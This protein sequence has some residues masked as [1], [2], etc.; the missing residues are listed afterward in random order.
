MNRRLGFMGIIVKDKGSV[1]NKINEIISEFGDFVIARLGIPYRE[2]ECSV[3]TLIVDIDT[4]TLGKFAGKL[5]SL[6]G[7]SVKSA[8][9]KEGK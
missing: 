6:P 9:S 3:I 7:V 4:D 5:G 8:L 2:R 1:V